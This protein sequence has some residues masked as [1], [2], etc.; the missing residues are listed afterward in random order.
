M[1]GIVGV[2]S[3]EPVVR[4]LFYALNTLQ[5]RGQESCGIAVSDDKDISCHKAN[6][7]A[8]HRIFRTNIAEGNYEFHSL[9]LLF[10]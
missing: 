7:M 8:R 6:I 2:Y 3:N 5:H 10:R 1:C 4:D 9:F